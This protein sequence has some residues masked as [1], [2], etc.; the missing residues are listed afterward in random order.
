MDDITLEDAWDKLGWAERHANLL[1]E[2]LGRFWDASNHRIVLEKDLDRGRYTFK[3]VDLEPTKVFWGLILGDSVHNARASLD[4]LMTRLVA[5]V[6]R[7]DPAEVDDVQFPIY[8]ESDNPPPPKGGKRSK[9]ERRG[10][11]RGGGP[12]EQGDTPKRPETR[13][14]NDRGVTKLRE[15]SAFL[16]YLATVEQLQPYNNGNPSVW[17]QVRGSSTNPVRGA[18]LV[19]GA[20]GEMQMRISS[21]VPGFSP[22]PE[23]L[24]IL[25]VLDNV[26]KHRS[27]HGLWHRLDPGR[28]TGFTAYVDA[29]EQLTPPEGYEITESFRNSDPLEGGSV[30]GHLQFSGPV[31]GTWTPAEDELRRCFPIDITVGAGCTASEPAFRILQLCLNA[32]R[33]VLYIF[34]P[35]F[36]QPRRPPHPVTVALPSEG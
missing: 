23:G 21:F 27:I 11:Q 29:F 32:A 7:Q 24:R 6:T 26:D 10:E 19:E 34:D 12:D 30:V 20:D 28:R 9:A 13:F 33:A 25:S 31:D 15:N 22:V 4:Y 18:R 8:F 2:E 14:R 17:G 35:V 5:I 16:G 1:F 36:G 3:V